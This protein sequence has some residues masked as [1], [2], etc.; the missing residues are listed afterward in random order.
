MGSIAENT[1]VSHFQRIGCQPENVSEGYKVTSELPGMEVV[2]VVV[3]VRSLS[4]SW[5]LQPE[6]PDLC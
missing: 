6:V 4:V 1:V 3:V 5:I 2:V